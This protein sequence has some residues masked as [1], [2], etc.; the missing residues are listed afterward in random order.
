MRGEFVD[1][2]DLR[3]Y[4]Y[5]AGTRGA[6]EPIVLLH[7]AFTSSHIWRD[8][9]ARLPKGHRVL[10]LDL[11]GH[12]RSDLPALAPLDTASHAAHVVRLLGVLGVEPACVVGHGMGAAVAAAIAAQSPAHVSRLLLC[13]PCLISAGAEPGAAPKGLR[14][15]ARLE[16]LWRVLP[17]EWLASALH[18][19]LLRGYG[20]RRVAAHPVDVYLK[21][22]RSLAGR[23]VAC[24]QLRAIAARDAAVHMP[25]LQQPISLMLGAD[26]PYLPR[27]GEALQHALSALAT[28]PLTVHRLAGLAHA[29]PEEAPDRLA[30]AVSDLLMQD[31]VRPGGHQ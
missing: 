5:A 15:L 10:V 12:G 20:N 25:T 1:L 14:R 7:G 30:V 11:L 8:L 17:P 31:P 9:V 23:D 4:C 16:R 3:L 26:D 2:G 18:T 13:N 22:Y 21:P 19:A 24:R 28:P 27:H 6:G 29:I